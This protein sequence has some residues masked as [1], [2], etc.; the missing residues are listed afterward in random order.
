[1]KEVSKRERRK[2]NEIRIKE[3]ERIWR[4]G[5][6]ERGILREKEDGCGCILNLQIGKRETHYYQV[7]AIIF[8]ILV[9]VIDI[10][11]LFMNL[12]CSVCNIRKQKNI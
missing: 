11:S 8:V 4:L 9:I 5:K 1:V 2:V 7:R 6:G 12:G 10:M 3:R